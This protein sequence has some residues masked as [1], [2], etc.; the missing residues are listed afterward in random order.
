[1]KSKFPFNYGA[2]D[3]VWKFQDVLPIKIRTTGF[4]PVCTLFLMFPVFSI[5]FLPDSPAFFGVRI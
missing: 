5:A 2:D 1:M 3:S 4:F